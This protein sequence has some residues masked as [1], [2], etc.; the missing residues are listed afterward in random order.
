[1]AKRNDSTLVHRLRLL[2]F[3]PAD[4]ARL[5]CRGRSPRNVSQELWRTVPAGGRAPQAPA[6]AIEQARRERPMGDHNLTAN[7]I[8]VEDRSNRTTII[9]ETK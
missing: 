9:P 5:A 8:A 1:L 7:P 3:Y 6:V 4:W 2:V